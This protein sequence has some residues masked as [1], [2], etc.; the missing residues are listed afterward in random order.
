MVRET[1]DAYRA[2]L[3]EDRQSLFDRFRLL[4]AA[5]KVVGVGSV[6]T[7]C[8]IALFTAGDDD[9]LILQMKEARA[10]VFETYAGAPSYRFQG[11]RVVSCQRALQAASDLFLGFANA[12][13][14]HDYYIRQLRDMKTSA[15]VDQMTAVALADY[16][17]FCGWALARAHSKASGCA[18]MIAGYLGRSA[19]F[20]DAIVEFAEAYAKQNDHDYAKLVDAV[21]SGRVKAKVAS[22]GVSSQR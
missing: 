18:A 11:G 1:F 4:D 5:Y 20:D 3:P 7:R 19:A 22:G 8:L 17:G 6:G 9:R 13:D 12:S 2:T 16:A 10:S 21:R 15:G 14:G